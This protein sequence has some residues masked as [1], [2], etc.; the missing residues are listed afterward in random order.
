VES[1]V[2]DGE[3]SIDE[4]YANMDENEVDSQNAMQ[5]DEPSAVDSHPIDTVRWRENLGKYFCSRD[6]ISDCLSNRYS[7]E[8]FKVERVSTCEYLT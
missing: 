6:G 8:A 2:L 7:I 1:Q 5:S 3:Q 4:D